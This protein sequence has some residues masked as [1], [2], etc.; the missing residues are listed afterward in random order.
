MAARQGSNGSSARASR[1]GSGNSGSSG[2]KAVAVQVAV[3]VAVDVVKCF[4]GEGEGGRR[5]PRNHIRCQYG[6]FNSIEY[7]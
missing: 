2:S 3:A 1:S 7:V 4:R 5:N 6:E